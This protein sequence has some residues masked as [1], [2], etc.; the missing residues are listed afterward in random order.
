[1]GDGVPPKSIIAAGFCALA[2][3]TLFDE[4]F[5]QITEL[6]IDHLVHRAVALFQEALAKTHGAVVNDAR[7]LKGE[8]ILVSSVTGNE[9]LGHATVRVNEGT[10]ETEMTRR[11]QLT[12]SNYT[13]RNS[14][15]RPFRR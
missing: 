12:T 11:Y 4:C 13:G 7:F 5:L 1:M 2:Q 3:T 9:M 10:K 8:E 14:P 6:L 15:F